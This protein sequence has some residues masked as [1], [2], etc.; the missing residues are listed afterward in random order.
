MVLK[1]LKLFLLVIA[2]PAVLLC[3]ASQINP[4][5]GVTAKTTA[6]D[7]GTCCKNEKC[8]GNDHCDAC[9]TGEF[10]QNDKTQGHQ[11]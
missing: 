3:L 8:D 7:H 10:C 6:C 11:Q 9:K 5:A 1:K 4:P 2:L